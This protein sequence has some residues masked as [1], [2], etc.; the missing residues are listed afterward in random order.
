MFMKE[1]LS[2]EDRK[3]QILAVAR[4]LFAK[5]GFDGTTLDDI[6]DKTGVS[7]PRVI[8]LFGSKLKIYEAIAAT[9]YRNHPLDKDLAE[10]MAK[11]DDFGVLK[12]FAAHVLV[13]TQKRED[14]ENLKI[15]MSARLK[16]DQFHKTHFHVQDTLMISH[17]EDYFTQ[18]AKEGAFKDINTRTIIYAFQAMV[19]NLGIYKNVMKKWSL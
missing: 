1:R 13:N 17:L 19:T 15:L 3:A 18:R 4:T 12:A 10:P 8:Q 7:R 11:K 5:K 14:R 6:A 16:E 9:A 2:A